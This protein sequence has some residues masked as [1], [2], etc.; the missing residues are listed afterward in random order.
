MAASD[1][2]PMSAPDDGHPSANGNSDAMLG[3]AL[4]RLLTTV[5][6][7][8]ALLPREERAD[9][10]TLIVRTAARVV[11]ARA[12]SLFLI[13]ETG[14]ELDFEVAIG[15]KAEEVRRFKVAIGQG[16]AGTVA[17]TGQPIAISGPEHDP[18]FAA[19]IAR[20]V[21]HI[22]QSILCVPLRHGD[23]TIGVLE[24]LD[25]EARDTFTQD[26]IELLAYFAEIASLATEQVR[27]QDDLR[28]ALTEIISTWTQSGD[29]VDA[30]ALVRS[31]I[32]AVLASTRM[33]PEYRA[34][35]ELAEMVAEVARAGEAERQLCIDCLRAFQRYA[36]AHARPFMGA[37]PWSP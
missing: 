10:L 21:G 3:Q 32:D 37:F 28:A 27:R 22:P 36:Q 24:V 14:A 9:L 13:D 2:P 34:T 1:H 35:L 12:A 5:S 23:H 15:P 17:A 26:D 4:R 11:G 29:D 20:S 31:G 8:D 16:I 7:V 30:D 33:G 19:E 6:G 18:R 25:K